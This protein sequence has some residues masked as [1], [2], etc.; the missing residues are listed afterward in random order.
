MDRL[1]NTIVL[2]CVIVLIGIFLGSRVFR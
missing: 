2:I 1:V